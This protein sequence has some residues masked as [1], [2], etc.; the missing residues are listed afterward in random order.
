MPSWDYGNAFKEFPCEHGV[1]VFDNGSKAKVCDITKELPGFMCDADLLFIDP[2][3]TQGNITAFYTKADKGSAPVFMDFHAALFERIAEIAPRACYVEMGKE[4]LADT[5]LSMRK[6]FPQ[7]TFFNSTYYHK[8]QN[9]CYIVYGGKKRPAMKLDGM[10]EEDAI[11]FLCKNEDYACI[12]D[13]CMGRGL[14]G[15]NAYMAKKRFVGSELNHKR[16]SVLL[17]RITKI[18][19]TYRILEG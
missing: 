13:L 19:G 3:W 17:Q 1:V 15:V 18:G 10:D 2:P 14:V 4:R 7:V 6:L 11:K 16:L 9:M 5:I 12:G 8:A